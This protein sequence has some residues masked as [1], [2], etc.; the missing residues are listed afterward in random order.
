MSSAPS[1]DAS[2]P[3]ENPWLRA[4]STSIRAGGGIILVDIN[5]PISFPSSYLSMPFITLPTLVC[6]E[7]CPSLSLSSS[8]TPAS[9]PSS[10]LFPL[11]LFRRYLPKSG[12]GHIAIAD[13][14][15]LVNEEI[16]ILNH[17]DAMVKNS[18]EEGQ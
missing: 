17:R 15:T 3:L 11:K 12:A 5:P 6:S 13:F 9:S 14:N 7:T 2:M 16:V 1:R 4:V 8:D 18:E 10:A